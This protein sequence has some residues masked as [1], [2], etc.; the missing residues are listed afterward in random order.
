ML[1]CVVGARDRGRA[2]ERI[3]ILRL[4]SRYSGAPRYACRYTS[5]VRRR[6]ASDLPREG[7]LFAFANLVDPLG[8]AA[9]VQRG[10]KLIIGMSRSL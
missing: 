2:G 8:A 4:A 7:S 1:R 6:P 5:S 10:K 9:N 3:A